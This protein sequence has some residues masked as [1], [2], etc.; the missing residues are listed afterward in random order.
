M[1]RTIA[2]TGVA[3]GIG[4]ELAGLLQSQGHRVIGF[5][6]RETSDGI[7]RFIPLDLSD[8]S[9]IEAAAAAVDVPLDGLC[10]NAGLPPRDGLRQRTFEIASSWSKVDAPDQP[11]G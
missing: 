7:D 3:G 8:T 5:D 6:I 2:V 9:S 10:N 1:A 11:V 4:A